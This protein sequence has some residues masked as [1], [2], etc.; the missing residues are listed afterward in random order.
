MTNGYDCPEYQLVKR[1]QFTVGV[2]L[3]LE[4]ISWLL[5][6]CDKQYSDS[7]HKI[8]FIDLPV[9]PI[10]ISFGADGEIYDNRSSI[11]STTWYNSWKA[12]H[13]FPPP[14][15]EQK[16]HHTHASSGFFF[17]IFY[18]APNPRNLATFS[19]DIL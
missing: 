15:S 17:T 9:H 16:T 6:V 14:P 13:Y 12:Y 11:S 2:R 5:V 1:S 19:S 8:F 10:N 3:V 7:D 18:T 4:L